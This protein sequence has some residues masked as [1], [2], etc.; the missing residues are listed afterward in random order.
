MCVCGGVAVRYLFDGSWLLASELCVCWICIFCSWIIMNDL[1]T[2]NL[3]VFLGFYGIQWWLYACL[4][5][6]SCVMAVCQVPRRTDAKEN[7]S[8]L[9]EAAMFIEP[10][11]WLCMQNTTLTDTHT[12]TYWL[13]CVSECKNLHINPGWVSGLIFFQLFWIKNFWLC[14]LEQQPD[15]VLQTSLNV[16]TE[17]MQLFFSLFTYIWVFFFF[18]LY[19]YA[20]WCS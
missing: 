2:L 18:Q 4:F 3:C 12:H 1:N 6:V 19:F 7:Q 15:R 10:F 14:I 9:Q 17:Y 16:L 5:K 13:V 20:G 8:S 11:G